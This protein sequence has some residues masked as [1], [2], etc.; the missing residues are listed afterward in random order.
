M[1]QAIWM[2]VNQRCLPH[3]HYPLKV[4]SLEA[5]PEI[6]R[7]DR[8]E[9]GNKTVTYVDRYEYGN[10]TVTRGT[11]EDYFNSKKIAIVAA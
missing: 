5:V 4:M 9:Y 6:T 11:W 7:V 1:G 3:G 2:I 8:Y 10:K